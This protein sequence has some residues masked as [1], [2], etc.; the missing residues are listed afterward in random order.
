MIQIK[1]AMS[2][3][4]PDFVTDVYWHNDYSNK[5]KWGGILNNKPCSNTKKWV[6]IHK[7]KKINKI[8]I[9]GGGQITL[10]E[11]N[12]IK[13]LNID[14]QYFNIDRRFLGDG[15]TRVKDTDSNAEKI[16]ITYKKILPSK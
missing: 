3:G 4:V 11:Y 7:K 13:K 1:K 10:D 5:C 12:L 15:N 16:G 8:F 14:Y 2:W 6:N 9:I